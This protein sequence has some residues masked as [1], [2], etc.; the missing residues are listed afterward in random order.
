[1]YARMFQ[2]AGQTRRFIIT[3][4]EQLGWEVRQ[5]EDSRVVWHA[6]YTDWHKVERARMAFAREAAALASTGWKES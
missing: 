1:M 3:T 5:E 4:A 2:K 6:C